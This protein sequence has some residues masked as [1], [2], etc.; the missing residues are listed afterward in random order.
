MA[1]CWLLRSGSDVSRTA[2]AMLPRLLV[3]RSF[4]VDSCAVAL[5]RTRSISVFAD[6]SRLFPWVDVSIAFLSVFVV[7]P[8][9]LWN[10]RASVSDRQRCSNALRDGKGERM[11]AQGDAKRPTAKRGGRTSVRRKAARQ[12]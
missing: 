10:I 2:R 5:S 12:Q 6:V 7:N 1:A 4:C 8:G 11:R 3:A 9:M